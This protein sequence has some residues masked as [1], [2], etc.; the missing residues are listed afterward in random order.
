M[1]RENIDNW[2]VRKCAKEC[3]RCEKEFEDKEFLFS[4]LSFDEGEYERGDFC[5]ACWDKGNPGLSS[6]K[7]MFVV[8]PPPQEEAVK[9]ENA[10][11][12][13]RKLLAKE[14]EEDLNAVF[15]L[16]VM[17]E[18]KKILVERDT[19]TLEDGRK[20]RIYEHKKT[21]ESFMV[22]DPELKLDELEEVQDEVVVLLGGQPRNAVPESTEETSKENHEDP[23]DSKQNQA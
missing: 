16:A 8:P 10:E 11:S 15:I 12:L 4:R 6:W 3:A 13:L 2:S 19:K 1:G 23:K 9:K 14:N 21:N 7:T 20:L 18:R 22:V 17:L 5:A